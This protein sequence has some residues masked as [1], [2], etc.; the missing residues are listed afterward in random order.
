MSKYLVPWQHVAARIASILDALAVLG[1][2]KGCNDAAWQRGW[3][4]GIRSSEGVRDD[5]REGQEAHITASLWSNVWDRKGDPG[6]TGP[7][8][9]TTGAKPWIAIF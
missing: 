4:A 9:D 5:L 3:L 2:R 7:W 1:L 8:P 6:T